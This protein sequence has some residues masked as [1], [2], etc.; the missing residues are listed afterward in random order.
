MGDTM[1]NNLPTIRTSRRDFIAATGAAVIAMSSASCL[2]AQGPVVTPKSARYRRFNISDRAAEKH[3]KSYETAITAMLALPPSDPRNWY[4]HAL[5]HTLDCPHGNWWFL[6]WHRGYTGWLETI[7]RELSGDP[8]FALPYWD[9]TESP[10]LP[11]SFLQGNLNPANFKITGFADFKAQFKET[12]KVFWSNL[13]PAQL[14]Q[15]TLRDYPSEDFLWASIQNDPPGQPNEASMFSDI[16]FVRLVNPP[17][18]Q[19]LDNVASRAVEISTILD[20]LGAT[21]FEEFGSH[22]VAYHSDFTKQG[23]LESQPHN[24]VHNEVGGLLT[25]PPDRQGFMR[26]F[27]S[28]VDPI[29]FMHHS[30]ID[31]LWDVWTR[32][33]LQRKYPIAPTSTSDLDVWKNEPFLFF[34]GPDGKSVPQQTAGDY[35]STDLFAYDY[36]PGSGEIVVPPTPPQFV[37]AAQS[38]MSATLLPQRQSA[39]NQASAEVKVP[40]TLPQDVRAKDGARIIARITVD[41]PDDSRNL[42]LHVLLNTPPD[43]HNVSF[44]DPG[45]A[46]TFEPFGGHHQVKGQNA[47][48]VT[49]SIG[50]TSSIERL[51]K[52]KRLLGSEPLKVTVVADWPGVSLQTAPIKVTDVSII[53]N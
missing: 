36:E 9:W 12:V 46:G 47:R 17:R 14:K 32:K 1:N 4:R 19:W 23:V 15:V 37:A 41:L 45:Y 21:T 3:L 38:T 40:V 6:P 29:F 44:T 49:F 5:I 27:L 53:T 51:A 7:C 11:D 50:L 43:A 24:L 34:V 33:Q 48:T 52:E 42:R 25:G 8:G 31:R 28:P 16:S 2:N 30:N 39:L 18:S 20:A 26:D 10:K 22:K 35:V 13:S